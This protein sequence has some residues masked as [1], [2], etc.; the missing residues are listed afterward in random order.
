MATTLD[1]DQHSMVVAPLL[2]GA[3]L[4]SRGEA[5][6]VAVRITEVEAYGGVGE[7]PAAHSFRG[8]TP[9]NAQMFEPAG[10]FYAYFTYGMHWC[11][12][13]VT[14]PGE[15]ATAVLLR[16][17]EVVQ[18]R[19]LAA[20]RRPRVRRDRDLARG[21]AN[22]TSCLAVDGSAN[23]ISVWSQGL[24]LVVRR[25][26]PEQSIVTGPRVGISAATDWP[27][28][29]WVRDDPSVSAYKPGRSRL[30]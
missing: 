19:D 26:L 16:A 5:G 11:L 21:P 20:A 13:V 6:T 7:D 3:L 15:A 23:G 18:G 29:F 12:N 1:L 24:R 8:R 10:R 9:R 4:V 27:W 2:L 30:A 28:R 25:P 14:G 22:L 17:G